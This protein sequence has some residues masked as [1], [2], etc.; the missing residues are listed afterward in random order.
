MSATD[1]A[2]A[3]VGRDKTTAKMVARSSMLEEGLVS[4]WH[5]RMTFVGVGVGIGISPKAEDMAQVIT[6]ARKTSYRSS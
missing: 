6:T 2:E 1:A 5:R 3:D 4:V